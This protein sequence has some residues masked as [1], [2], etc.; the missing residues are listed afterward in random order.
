MLL[1]KLLQ[2]SVAGQHHKIFRQLVIYGKRGLSPAYRCL[3]LVEGGRI[4][5]T[6]DHLF[7]LF[8]AEGRGQ[9][10]LYRR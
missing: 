6:V 3:H 1:S 4:A 5:V 9:P 2:I 7:P 10:R 8:A